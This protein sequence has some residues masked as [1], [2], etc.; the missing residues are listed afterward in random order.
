MLA[1]T[2]FVQFQSLVVISTHADRQSVDMSITV[3]LFIRLFVNLSLCTVTD[4]SAGDKA[5]GVK[6]CTMVHG[7]P[8]H[9]IS[10]FGNFALPEVQNPT[11]RRAAASI[12]DRRQSPSDCALA[13]SGGDWRLSAIFALGMYVWIYG[14]SA[15]DKASGVKF[16]TAVYRH[17]GQRI[18][19]FGERCFL[20]SPK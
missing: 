10:N 14:R 7:C 15:E 12:A 9:G 5:S 2:I 6:F 18:S 4:F 19:H 20:I 11:N 8:G 3:C 16:C 13:V 17:P 1:Y